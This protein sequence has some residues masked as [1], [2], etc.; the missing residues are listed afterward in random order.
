[1]YASSSDT[2]YNYYTQRQRGGALASVDGIPVFRASRRHVQGG[3][4]LGDV[5][6]SA[7]RWFLPVALRGASTFANAF[8]KSH[9]QGATMRDA[10]KSAIAPTL[11]AA[12]VA[13]KKRMQAKEKLQ[14]PMDT[15][16]V[17]TGRKRRRRG[18][19]K[20]KQKRRKTAKGKSKKTKQRGGKKT[21]NSTKSKKQRG[22]KKGSKKHTATKKRKATKKGATAGSILSYNF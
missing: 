18:V 20:G 14:A 21:K 7:F 5:L 19:Y 17:G 2:F 11:N 6:R 16:Q 1:M 22:G 3:A 9:D 13:I 8:L 15:A 10:A 12:A 4:G